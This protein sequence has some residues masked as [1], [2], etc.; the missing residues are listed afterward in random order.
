M[1]RWFG[2]VLAAAVVLAGRAPEARAALRLPAAV[3]VAV[4]Q[5]QRLDLGL[6]GVVAVRVIGPG[7]KW[8]QVDG[9]P[10]TRWRQVPA[11]GLWLEPQRAGVTTLQLRLF[12]LVPWRPVQLRAVRVP[13]VWTGGQS[14]GVVLHGDGPLV[15]R[16]V[17]VS[18]ADGVSAAPA[19]RADLEAG[20]IVLTAGGRAVHSPQAVARAVEAAGHAGRSLGLVVLRRGRTERVRV[21]PVRS[22]GGRYQIGAWLVRDGAA[23]VGTLTFYQ[24]PTG[25]YGALGHPV[26]N[27][28]GRTP[29]L[30]APGTLWP[31]VVSGLVPGRPGRPGEKVGQLAP[32]GRPMGSVRAN[33]PVGVFGRLTTPPA[34]GLVAGTWPLALVDQ[35]HRG[36]AR[37]LTVIDGQRVRAY[38]VDITAVLPQRR[39]TSRGF[40]IR[41]VDPRLLAESGG[42]VQGMSG[43][44]ILQDGRLVGAVTHVFV[45][46]PARG[47]GVCA[48]WMASMAGLLS[49]T[50]LGAS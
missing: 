14:I 19:S 10:A 7:A 12:G 36:G 8:L 37:L 26:L 30:A 3:V 43:S 45:D 42:I 15:V 31:T 16:T 25:L 41:V 49:P 17:P 28:A 34:A 38:Q 46:D 39:M 2:A 5:R 35:I 27:T 47:Y 24:S 50:A 32:G 18:Q 23:G 20:D 13:Q 4:G 48:C 11:A 44:P 1:A 6:P 40:V 29:Q 21:R 22:A 33:T 9:A